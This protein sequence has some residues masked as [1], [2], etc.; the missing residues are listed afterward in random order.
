LTL[1]ITFIVT[2]YSALSDIM[3]SMKYQ[4]LVVCYAFIT[5]STNNGVVN[6]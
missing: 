1:F 6:I 3:Y 2:L 5:D 4:E